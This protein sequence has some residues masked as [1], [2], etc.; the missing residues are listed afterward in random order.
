MNWRILQTWSKKI[1]PVAVTFLTTEC[2]FLTMSICIIFISRVIRSQSKTMM[3][4]SL[5]RY[6]WKYQLHVASVIMTRLAKAQRIT[7]RMCLLGRGASQASAQRQKYGENA[8][9]LTIE[10]KPNSYLRYVPNRSV[11]CHCHAIFNRFNLVI[12]MA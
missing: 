1:I 7:H 10:T 6:F 9:K 5:G 11:S 8:E 4:F 3:K 12:V 2:N